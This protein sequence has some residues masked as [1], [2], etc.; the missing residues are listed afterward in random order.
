MVPPKWEQGAGSGSLRAEAR[1]LAGAYR[2]LLPAPF[3]GSFERRRERP[4]CEHRDEPTPI[5]RGRMDIRRRIH[6]AVR[7]GVRRGSQQVVR[8][9]LV[10]QDLP[11]LV[12]QHWPVADA[13]AR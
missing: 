9:T 2:S 10:L 3:L 7:G 4:P 13:Q 6:I 12:R 5:R 1:L 8:S 11:R